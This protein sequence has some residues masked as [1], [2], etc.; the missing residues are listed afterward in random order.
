MVLGLQSKA[1]VCRRILVLMGSPFM[2]G[3]YWDNKVP[4]VL[5]IVSL[6]S[7][8]IHAIAVRLLSKFV[9]ACVSI[10]KSPMVQSHTSCLS[11][12][13]KPSACSYSRLRYPAA[14]I[15]RE[16]SIQQKRFLL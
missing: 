8:Y 6:N 1:V 11:P 14:F 7:S 2:L 4:S 5:L 9:V 13:K 10:A 16:R 12:P 15:K 3:R